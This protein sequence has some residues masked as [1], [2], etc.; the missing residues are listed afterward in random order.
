MRSDAFHH[1]DFCPTVIRQR[2]TAEVLN[3]LADGFVLST[4]RG[5]AIWRAFYP[6]DEAYRAA[7]SRLRKK[8]LIAERGR[9]GKAPVFE[10]CPDGEA[11]AAEVC[12][13][14]PP[15][16]K[17]WNGIWYQVSYDVPEAD[18]RYR[19]VL[20][21]FLKRRRMGCLQKSLWI[22][23]HDIRPD[24]AD[25]VLTAQ[26]DL[27]SFLFESRTVL[28]RPATDIVQHAWDMERLAAAQA[29]YVSA[30]R[31]HLQRALAG[32][33][34]PDRLRELLRTELS[35]YLTVM[36]KDPLLPRPLWP[37]GYQGEKAWR[38]HRR[39]VRKLAPLL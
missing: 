3:L 37:K 7:C 28:G 13:R 33:E 35:V 12:R 5:T 23:P 1:P 15:W 38:F 16:A 20:R 6:N 2:L 8:G 11:A 31:E 14:R 24:Y 39:F 25:L 10:I 9:E 26:V 18:R 34:P 17:Q 19:T 36:E 30:Y 27:Y 21:D 32:H 29:W 22:T 4:R